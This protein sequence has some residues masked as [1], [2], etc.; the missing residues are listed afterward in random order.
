MQ[1]A[2]I[3]AL[4]AARASDTDLIADRAHRIHFSSIV[5]DMHDGT[6]QDLRPWHRR[7]AWGP[8]C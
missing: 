5:L 4:G 2:R 7:T 8:R 6:P 1:G 3:E